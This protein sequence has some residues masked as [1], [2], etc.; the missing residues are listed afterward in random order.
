MDGGAGSESMSSGTWGDLPSGPQQR[1]FLKSLSVV[2][3]DDSALVYTGAA[4]GTGPTQAG[5]VTAVISPTNVCKMG[6][7]DNCYSTPNRVGIQL[8]YIGGDGGI[9]R[10]FATPTVALTHP[11][12]AS[13]VLDVVIGL[14][15]IGTPLRWTGATGSLESWKATGLGTASGEIHIRLHPALTPEL[16]WS[17]HPEA[18]GCTATPIRDCE[19]AQAHGESLTA[20]LVLSLDNTLPTALTGAV[21]ATQ[22]AIM[23]YLQ[24]GGTADAPALDL[25]V[26]SS[27]LRA[28]GAPQ[29]GTLQA[30]LPAAGLEQIY[31]MTPEA[32]STRLAAD[33]RGD[34][35]T[36]DAPAFAVRSEDATWNAG[37]EVTVS[38]ITFSAPTYR[39][40]AK[41]A[42]APSIL[43]PA[44]STGTGSS[45][46]PTPKAP[47]PAASPIATVLSASRKK[48]VVVALSGAPAGAAKASLVVK[49][50]SL[51][52]GSVT[53]G[54]SGA[55]TLALKPS[56]SALRKLK[57]VKK[58]E[59]R[60]T[61][62]GTPVLVQTLK[63]K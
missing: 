4:G 12:T 63:L 50:K 34:P 40:A 10:N 39:L 26:A 42:L 45:A 36:S 11:V 3:G 24:P 19:V 51:I 7:S 5:D 35:G 59:L 2:N 37:L 15:T 52:S 53:V 47:A 41:G 30:F 17:A 27:H 46:T 6:Q 56:R 29:L 28:D 21:F 58:A 9:R 8:G 62:P 55:A 23:G 60:V 54:A 33:R 43:D 31:A 16:D 48:G 44:R 25:Q 14:N 61:L 22:R 1:P 49:G 32:A 13:T 57:S 18:S 38:G 20:G